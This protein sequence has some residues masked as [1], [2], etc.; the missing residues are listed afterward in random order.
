MPVAN[1][2]T[3]QRDSTAVQEWCDGMKEPATYPHPCR[4]M[5]AYRS[6]NPDPI[7]LEAGE[8]CAVSEKVD[9]WHDNPEWIWVWCTNREGKSG[10]V[11]RS[12]IRMLGDGKTGKVDEA[13]R[14]VEL[15][16]AVS[17]ELVA[18]REESGWLWC[19]NTYNEYGW[20]PMEH[21]AW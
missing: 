15:T 10:W 14:A 11:P 6:S 17:D 5:T 2:A 16:V 20:V 18:E 1:G 19:R 13:Y 12:A 4:V 3:A 21:V 9:Y 8:I 7:A